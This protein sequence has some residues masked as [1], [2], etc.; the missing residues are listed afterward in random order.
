MATELRFPVEIDARDAAKELNKLER[1]MDKLKKSM[2]SG[3]AKRAPIVEQ[4]KQAQDEAV[5]ALDKVDKL[6]SAL[7]ESE[8]KTA[9]TA[10]V[11]PQTWIDETQ[12]QTEIK[13][14][15]AEQE[16]ILKSKEAAAEKLAAQDAK[17][18]AQ[19]EKQTA[20]LEKQEAR[21][22]ELT[23]QI[24]DASKGADVKAALAAA[25]ESIK[26]GIKNILKY[27]IGIRSLYIL[28]RKLK[29]YTV[30]AVK[31]YAENDPETQKRIND[32][33]ASLQGLQASWGAAFAP[34]LNAVIPILKTLI[35]WITHVVNAVAMLL[36]VISGK[37]TFKKAIANTEKLSDNLASGAGSAKELKKQLMG[38]DTLTISQDSS[39]GG[40]GGGGS[41]GGAYDWVE[42]SIDTSSFLGQVGLS[43]KDVLFDWSSLTPE[44]IAEKCFAAIPTMAGVVIGGMV[45]GLPGALIGGLVG[46][47]LGILADSIIFDHDGELSYDEITGMIFSALMMMGFAAVGL[48]LGGPVGAALGAA[49]GLGL[50]L[51]IQELIPKDETGLKSM[52]LL[53]I[54]SNVL[55]LIG[56]G[57]IGFMVGGPAGAALGAAIG[58]GLTLAVNGL[59]LDNK[60]V[61][62]VKRWLW[63]DGI[64]PVLDS[65]KFLI[66]DP[67]REL[68][69]GIVDR[70]EELKNVNWADIGMNIVNGIGEGLSHAWQWLTESISQMCSN[71]L[72]TA[73]NILGIH[74][75]SKVF[76]EQIGENIGAGIEEGLDDSEGSLGSRIKSL[77]T[78]MIEAVNDTP[79]SIGAK[80]ANVAL[81]A[82]PA[83]AMGGVVSP[84]AFS[85]GYGYGVS[86]ELESKLD[87]LLERLTSGGKPI[88]IHT[89][90]D[91]D[92]RKLGEAVYTYTEERNRGRGK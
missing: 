87:A 82:M 7:A 89:T 67:V 15:L 20:E 36:S 52:S 11:D 31:A 9:I 39:S 13:A 51:V 65:L 10:N 42:E 56:G 90:V 45:G 29:Q 76:R 58:L 44:Q 17:I 81:P 48:T 26:G 50:S 64:L 41:S 92:K 40:G 14:Q 74:S 28:F 47:T 19:L 43:I 2:A 21:A 54:F 77:S 12:R 53:E 32:L 80:L 27:G 22:G 86:P 55:G 49:I 8:A 70:F 85:S 5:A 88:E 1:D 37:S 63:D 33:K 24:T 30:D 62:Q 6:K 59:D 83:V 69:E 46:L 23:K 66:V 91:L 57:L 25:Q 72:Q 78:S 75:P 61:P 68:I 84:N 4:L 35:D 79:V 60:W 3:E 71:L 18:V 38:I 16:K 73:K 34:I